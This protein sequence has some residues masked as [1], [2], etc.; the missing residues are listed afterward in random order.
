M[1]DKEL[2]ALTAAT[3]LGSSDL[4]LASVGGN[5]RKI[6]FADMRASLALIEEYTGDGTTGTK[7]FS[8]IPG[9]FRELRLQWSVRSSVSATS[10]SMNLTFNG[11]TGSNY[12]RQHVTGTG[13]TVNTAES[14]GATSVAL[15]VSGNT[16]TAGAVGGGTLDIPDYAGAVFHK[17]GLYQSSFKTATSSGGIGMRPGILHYRSASAISSL[18]LALASGNFMTG[19]KLRLYGIV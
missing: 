5:S 14:L 9:T 10:E 6:T 13:S 4:L 2:S 1:A 19:S 15:T 11:D 16:A 8:S 12:D 3:A 18:T 17:T 7:T